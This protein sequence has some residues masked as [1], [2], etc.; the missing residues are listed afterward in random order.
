MNPRPLRVRSTARQLQG[1]DVVRLPVEVWLK[2]EREVKTNV[3]VHL[4][5]S[6]VV[7]LRTYFTIPKPM[8]T[9]MMR[10]LDRVRLIQ[11]STKANTTRP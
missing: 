11:E 9:M 4:E 8:L 7:R 1:R 6:L 2:I 5:D 10:I 3:R